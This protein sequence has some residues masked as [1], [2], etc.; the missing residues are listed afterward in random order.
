VIDGGTFTTVKDYDLTIQGGW[1]GNSSSTNI[2]GASTFTGDYRFEVSVDFTGTF[3][4]V[5]K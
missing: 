1:D 4:L 5:S 2:S 3:V